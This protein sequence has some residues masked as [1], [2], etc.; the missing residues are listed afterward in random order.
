MKTILVADDEFDMTSTLRA[1]LEGE[2]Y[3]VETCI[4]GRA[5]LEQVRAS[6]PDLV[7]MDVM[8]PLI[9]GF[10]V[11]HAMRQTPGLDAVPVVLMSSI[12]PG[13]RREDYRWQ[14]FLRKPF[15]LDVL[16][17][18]VEKLIGRPALEAPGR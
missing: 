7:L 8:M 4:D 13:V 9:S 2:G 15:G 12:P 17:K 10:E 1:I 16:T 14:A 3:R 5:A 6:R 11:L 18:T